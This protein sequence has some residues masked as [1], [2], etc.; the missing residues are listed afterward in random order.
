M[1]DYYELFRRSYWSVTLS[2][3]AVS[4]NYGRSW[5]NNPYHFRLPEGT[6]S[7]RDRKF[8][9]SVNLLQDKAR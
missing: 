5:R 1:C 3:V 6:T 9:A 7:K 8:A 4:V 2:R